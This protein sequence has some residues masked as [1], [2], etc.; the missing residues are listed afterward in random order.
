VA[1]IAA[2]MV[3]NVIAQVANPASATWSDYL[4]SSDPVDKKIVA[5]I[6]KMQW[7]EACIVWGR[8]AKARKDLRRMY[9]F[10]E[11]LRSDGTINGIDL[12]GARGRDPELG[13]TLCG[14]L[15]AM[16]RPDSTNQTETA[17]RHS[18]QLVYRSRR[19]YVYTEGKDANGVVRSIQR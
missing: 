13:M 19:I 15:A 18:A 7:W 16:G 3:G 10:Q 14:V 1:M 5:Q 4:Q 9:A 2:A 17:T 8:E 6:Q 12:G 11:F